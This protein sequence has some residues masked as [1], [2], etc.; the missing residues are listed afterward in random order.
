MDGP[1]ADSSRQP[2]RCPDSPDDVH[3]RGDSQAP[4]GP[5]TGRPEADRSRDAAGAVRMVPEWCAARVGAPGSSSAACPAASGTSRCTPPT[6]TVQAKPRR[7][8]QSREIRAK[9]A[10][11]AEGGAISW[12]SHE[13]LTSR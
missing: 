6:F 13:L 1:H 2:A 8:L 9:D 10:W 11:L 5:T 7:S 4:D 3:T 12:G